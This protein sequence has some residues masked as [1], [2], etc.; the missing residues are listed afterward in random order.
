MRVPHAVRTVAEQVA[1]GW[2]AALPELVAE[3]AREWSVAVVGEPL[4]GGTR[5]YVTRVRTAQGTDAVL[6]VSVPDDD[7]PQRINALRAAEGRGHA[8]VLRAD[9]ARCALL[10]EALGPGVAALGWPPEQ[11]IDALCSTLLRAWRPARDA[12]R[13]VLRSK[14]DALGVLVARLWEEQ[15]RP[16]SARVVD[17]ALA[18]ARRR[19]DD[20]AEPVVVHGDP[21][22]GNLLQV[23]AARPGAESGFVFVD[24]DGF[25]APKAYDLGVVVRDWCLQLSGGDARATARGYCAR[26]AAR[27]GVAAQVVWESG[28]LERVSSGLYAR[29]LGLARIGDPFLATAERLTTDRTRTTISAC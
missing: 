7:V 12:S 3:L 15:D 23:K 4:G 2:L 10:L 16:C 6:K 25:V 19:A 17:R 21:H 14:A 20:P 28:F 1:P 22:P 29:S 26:A 13:P 5:S 27:T 24:P 9:V 8:L 18:Y 11:Q